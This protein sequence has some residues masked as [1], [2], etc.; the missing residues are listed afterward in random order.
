M[1]M[2][3]CGRRNSQAVFLG[4]EKLTVDRLAF[5][6]VKPACTAVPLKRG[7]FIMVQ[8]NATEVISAGL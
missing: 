3:R 8:T 5:K 1:Y 6:G 7:R 4:S 2:R